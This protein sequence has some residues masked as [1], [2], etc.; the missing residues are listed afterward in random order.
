[1]KKGETGRGF[2][3]FRKHVEKKGNSRY[4]ASCQSCKFHDDEEGCQNNEVTAFDVVKEEGRTY[5]AYWRGLE[6]ES[7]RKK[8]ENHDDWR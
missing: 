5:C 2:N 3:S 7:S 6:A 1:M 4:F 8:K